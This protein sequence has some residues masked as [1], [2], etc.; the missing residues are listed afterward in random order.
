MKYRVQVTESINHSYL[1]E[2][3]SREDA[4][5][6]YQNFNNEELKTLDEDGESF[7]ESHPWEIE[8]ENET[9]APALIANATHADALQHIARLI[10]ANGEEFT[11]GECMDEVWVYLETLGI[12]PEQY[13]NNSK[14]EPAPALIAIATHADAS[15]VFTASAAAPLRSAVNPCDGGEPRGFGV[16]CSDGSGE[17]LEIGFSDETAAERFADAW[18]N[19][20]ED[21]TARVGLVINNTRAEWEGYDLTEKPVLA[22]QICDHAQ[23]FAGW[24][25]ENDTAHFPCPNCGGIFEHDDWLA[26][27]DDEEEETEIEVIG[28]RCL[29][30]WENADEI[31][32]ISFGEYEEKDKY[33]SYDV[34]D[35]KIFYYADPVE[36][37]RLTTTKEPHADGWRIVSY[38]W[39]TQ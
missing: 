31:V 8:E 38:E 5:A 34:P 11:D 3:D 28:A 24:L 17:W 16:Y 39:V 9:P 4:R 12:D 18:K 33:D 36:F 37:R 15:P 25:D 29:I 21:N 2:A 19:Y 1:I 27:F 10:A 23:E 26:F 35:E 22:C 6:I 20:R 14:P 13:R 30:K 7:W 32:Y